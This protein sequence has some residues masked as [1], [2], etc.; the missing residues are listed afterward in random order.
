MVNFPILLLD[1]IEEAVEDELMV[2]R[3]EERMLDNEIAHLSHLYF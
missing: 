3:Y 2:Q 1:Q